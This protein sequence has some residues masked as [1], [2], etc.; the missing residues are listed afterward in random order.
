MLMTDGEIRTAME[1]GKLHM[2]NFSDKSLQPASYDMRVGSRLLI[3]NDSAEIDLF[4]KG[5]AILQPGV[6]ALVTTHERVRLDDTIAGHIGVKSY[7]TR[8]G[9]VMLTGLQIDPGFEGALVIG[10]YNASP[11]SL[12]LEY[13]APFCT[14]EF[15]QLAQPVKTPFVSG[16]EQKEGNIPRADKDYLRTLETQSLS[17]MSSSLRQLTMDVASLNQSVVSL[18]DSINVMQWT[19]GIGLTVVGII[20]GLSAVFAALK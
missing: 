8:K 17:E 3:S 19:M 18:R 14:V 13:L 2:D 5:S 1:S 6:F 12:T 20:S 16:D 15:H 7:Y 10:L 11:R 4:Q 9:V